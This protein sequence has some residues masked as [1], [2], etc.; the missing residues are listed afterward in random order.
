VLKTFW[1][2]IKTI[3][4]RMRRRGKPM[5]NVY[6]LLDDT[7]FDQRMWNDATLKEM[8]MNGRQYNLDIYCCLQY[9]KSVTASM[10]GQFDY[11]Y[12]FKERAPENL[13]K[14]YDVFAGGFFDSKLVFETVFRSCTLDRRAFVI[15][16]ADVDENEGA[17]DG[18]VFFYKAKAKHREFSIGCEAMWRYHYRFYNQHYESDEEDQKTAAVPGTRDAPKKRSDVAVVLR[19]PGKPAAKAKPKTALR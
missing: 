14:V 17:F 7:G 15:K 6:L 3:N 9:M 18:G 4:G 13:R 2:A 19:K 8:L 16:N 5:V 1:A 12:I 11:I 10:R